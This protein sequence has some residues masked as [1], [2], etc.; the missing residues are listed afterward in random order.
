MAFPSVLARPERGRFGPLVAAVG[1][2]SRCDRQ[3]SWADSHC[4]RRN[5]LDCRSWLQAQRPAR[6]C[7]HA[8]AMKREPSQLSGVM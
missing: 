1:L 2:G 4:G 8:T 5:L 6:V 3:E 7:A